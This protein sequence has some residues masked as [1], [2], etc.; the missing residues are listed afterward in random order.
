[1]TPW[2]NIVQSYITSLEKPK[3]T[4]VKLDSKTCLGCGQFLSKDQFYSKQ[5]NRD[6]VRSRC[7][8]CYAKNLRKGT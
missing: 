8:T 3:R 5:E 6:G 7:K 1:M 4:P 2:E